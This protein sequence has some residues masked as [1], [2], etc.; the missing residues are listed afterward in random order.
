MPVI[1]DDVVSYWCSNSSDIRVPNFWPY[2][3]LE[4]FVAANWVR[5]SVERATGILKEIENIRGSSYTL[6]T[7]L[8]WTDSWAYEWVVKL[9]EK[10]EWN[11]FISYIK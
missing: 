8:I 6:D 10:E 3:W 9:S 7:R 2:H 11:K 4:N 5:N 1:I